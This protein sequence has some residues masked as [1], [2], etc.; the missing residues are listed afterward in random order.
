MLG[1]QLINPGLN[2]IFSDGEGKRS[3]LS[4]FNR[5]GDGAVSRHG[6]GDVQHSSFSERA[7]G[8]AREVSPA[9]KTTVASNELYYNQQRSFDM[10]VKTRD[11]DV[12]TIKVNAEESLSSSSFSGEN[13]QVVVT[14]FENSYASSSRFSFSVEG[15]LDEGELAALNDLFAQVNDI[16]DDFYAGD[17]EMAFNQAM[18]VGYDVNELAAFAVNMRRSE[19]VAVRQAYTEIAQYA[20]PVGAEQ[21]N[22]F[23]NMMDKL[24]DFSA[25]A[26]QVQDALLEGQNVPDTDGQLLGQLLKELVPDQETPEQQRPDQKTPAGKSAFNEFVDAVLG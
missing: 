5:S 24:A 1:A 17:V 11:G 2:Q 18:E 16:A 3:P 4:G 21:E 25:K 20:E 22:P 7:M 8:A 10:Q 15:E 14:E 6:A 23:Q 13:D 12:V 9:S 26:Q 19:V